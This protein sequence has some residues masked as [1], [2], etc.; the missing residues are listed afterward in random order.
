VDSKVVLESMI[1]S[2]ASQAEWEPYEVS[3][4]YIRL[5][6]LKYGGRVDFGVWE[7][8][9]RLEYLGQRFICFAH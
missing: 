8:N 2:K 3:I 7:A 1:I 5:F 9:H 6:V 4:S